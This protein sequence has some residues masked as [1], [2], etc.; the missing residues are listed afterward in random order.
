M[1]D[2]IWAKKNPKESL[3]EHTDSVVKN[4]LALKERYF[5]LLLRHFSMI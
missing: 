2:Y 1:L 5:E 4:L 3:A